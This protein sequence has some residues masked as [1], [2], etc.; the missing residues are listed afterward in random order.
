MYHDLLKPPIEYAWSW[1]T[2]YFVLL[3]SA[4]LT[5]IVLSQYVIFKK[6]TQRMYHGGGKGVTHFE[7]PWLWP[8]MSIRTFSDE[9]IPYVI[10]V[11]TVNFEWINKTC[12][13][14]GCWPSGYAL[15]YS[16][17]VLWLTTMLLQFLQIWWEATRQ[18]RDVNWTQDWDFIVMLPNSLLWQII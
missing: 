12:C 10:L 8:S 16:T 15:F 3:L 2:I 14:I 11:H 17:F 13:C 4:S 18:K 6:F 5:N 7:G 9:R 1:P